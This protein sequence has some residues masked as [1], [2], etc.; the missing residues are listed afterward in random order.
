MDIEFP[1]AYIYFFLA[2]HCKTFMQP[3][4]LIIPVIMAYNSLR[5][6]GKKKSRKRC[7][8]ENLDAGNSTSP[9]ETTTQ[10]SSSNPF[11]PE[12]TTTTTTK[13]ESRWRQL[14]WRWNSDFL[15][16]RIA[17][18][19]KWLIPRCQR[20]RKENADE[21]INRNQGCES[22]GGGSIWRSNLEL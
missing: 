2:W 9:R 14:C 21:L 20:W 6:H 7:Y 11:L 19:K 18:K 16:M 17:T 1:V 4:F 22:G 5:F 10:K 8:N 15:L 13:N 3:T 12:T